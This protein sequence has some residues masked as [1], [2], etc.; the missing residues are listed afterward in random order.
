MGILM[1]YPNGK[2]KALTLSYDDGVAQDIK[3]IEIMQKYG[4]K[5]TFNINTG[6]MADEDA[7]GGKGRMS[8]RQIIDLYLKSKNEVAVHTYTHP[9]LEDM[10]PV[11]VTDEILRDRRNIENMFGTVTRG[12]A[13]PYGTYNDD[14]VN[15]LKACGIVYSRTTISTEWFDIP[16]N[17]LLLR[18]TCHH[19]NPRLF[20]LADKFLDIP[21]RDGCDDCWL[22]YLWGHS[23]E[24]D[25]D[26]NWE[27]IE[28]FAQKTGGR[29]DI[30]YAT[31]IEIYDYI[32]AYK[33]LIYNADRTIVYNPTAIDLWIDKDAKTIKISSGATVT[34]D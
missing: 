9:H 18:A 17:W 2:S 22:F 16:K 21:R 10:S 1:R 25:N 32:D 34:L 24:F 4:L 6:L 30:W 27:R 11:L 31:N 14:V 33:K 3:L 20:E 15:C 19:N 13:Y 7:V 12:M 29:N 26:S 28:K 23:Y 5:G 8:K